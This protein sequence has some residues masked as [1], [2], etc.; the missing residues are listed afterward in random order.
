MNEW[1]PRFPQNTL[2]WHVARYFITPAHES[3]AIQQLQRTQSTFER[4]QAQVFIGAM[5][6][7][8]QR[9]ATA[10]AL[11]TDMGEDT[12][13]GLPEGAIAQWL[14]NEHIQ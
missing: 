1:L 9:T 14:M 3:L 12:L 4:A 5:L 6:F 13:R 2:F 8:N 10:L 7:L 11:L